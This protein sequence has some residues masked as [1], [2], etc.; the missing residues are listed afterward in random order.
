MM[1]QHRRINEGSEFARAIGGAERIRHE[2]IGTKFGFFARILDDIGKPGL[3]EKARKKADE[4]HRKDV[5]DLISKRQFDTALFLARLYK[6]KDLVRPIQLRILAREIPNKR[7]FGL[8]NGVLGITIGET[9]KIALIAALDAIER[10]DVTALQRLTTFWVESGFCVTFSRSE[11]RK[12]VEEHAPEKA[13]VFER[14]W[15]DESESS[16]G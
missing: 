13:N 4:V 15:K 10:N 3:A 1:K 2:K 14:I 16:G 5:E 6:F 11:I 9:E 12:L 8:L 7:T